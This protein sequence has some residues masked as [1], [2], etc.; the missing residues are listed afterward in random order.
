LATGG[1]THDELVPEGSMIAELAMLVEITHATTI[2]AK[3][4]VKALR[5]SREKMHELMQKDPELAAHFSSRIL[6]RLQSMAQELLA[7]DGLLLGS[8]DAA[9]KA[10]T[11]LTLEKSARAQATH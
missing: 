11:Q 7:V 10:L 5:L 3:D 4:Q 9:Q 2:I 6:K 1:K 8:R